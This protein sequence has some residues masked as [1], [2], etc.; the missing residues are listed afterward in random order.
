VEDP[1]DGESKLFSMD[2]VLDK[3]SGTVETYYKI[4]NISL[5]QYGLDVDADGQVDPILLSLYTKGNLS[6]TDPG[7]VLDPV[8]A[9]Q[10]LSN[11]QLFPLDPYTDASMV[12]TIQFD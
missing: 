12:D 7:R 8:R 6:D 1:E 9:V 4:D 5:G 10:L 2:E 3:I 11:F